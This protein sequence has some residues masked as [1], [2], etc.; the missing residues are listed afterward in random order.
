MPLSSE[1]PPGAGA[2]RKVRGCHRAA[3]LDLSTAQPPSFTYDAFPILLL[4]IFQRSQRNR[5]GWPKDW[6]A[7]LWSWMHYSWMPACLGAFGADHHAWLVPRS[8][9]KVR[10]IYIQYPVLQAG[11]EK[12]LGLE[13]CKSPKASSKIS[14][15]WVKTR[16]LEHFASSVLL[17]ALP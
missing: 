1:V 7:W 12:V 8:S 3:H 10:L 16:N 9:A 11:R 4:C 5:A 15:F 17:T 6:G 14:V 13:H 2:G